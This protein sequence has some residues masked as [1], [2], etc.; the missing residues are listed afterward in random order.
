[1]KRASYVRSNRAMRPPTE[2]STKEPRNTGLYTRTHTYITRVRR[3]PTAVDWGPP[4]ALNEGW[5][6]SAR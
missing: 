6:G 5:W 2:A 1:M 3:Q 4:G